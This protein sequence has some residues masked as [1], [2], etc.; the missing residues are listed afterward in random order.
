[1]SFQEE[2]K[3]LSASQC[4]ITSGARRGHV[5]PRVERCEPLQQPD[6][7][8]RYR[9]LPSG[10]AQCRS[11]AKWTESC[12][13][14]D[15]KPIAARVPRQ[16]CYRVSRNDRGVETWKGVPLMLV[17]M[18]TTHSRRKD[19]KA[20]GGLKEVKQSHSYI[21]RILFHW[22]FHHPKPSLLVKSHAFHARKRRKR[23]E[24]I[25]P[26]HALP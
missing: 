4:I 13:F 17:N 23:K 14:D 1:M 25:M 19:P 7:G 16:H 24:I 18:L 22:V 2:A 5:S 21:T 6:L 3:E 9:R 26:I 11:I 12:R 15:M 20:V 10:W 8:A